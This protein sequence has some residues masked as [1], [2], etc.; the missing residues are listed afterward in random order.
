MIHK[1]TISMKITKFNYLFLFRQ[2]NN[3][4]K[5]FDEKIEDNSSLTPNPSLYNKF[6]IN[7]YMIPR[8]LK[9]GK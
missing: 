4:K 2:K 3:E 5:N 7:K 6:L 1:K 9:I 8:R